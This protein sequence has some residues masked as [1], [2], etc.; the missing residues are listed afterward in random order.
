MIIVTCRDFSGWLE[1]SR[2]YLQFLT[3]L[4]CSQV[5]LVAQ[6]KSQQMRE[7]HLMMIKIRLHHLQWIHLLIMLLR[8]LVHPLRVVRACKRCVNVVASCM[9]NTLSKSSDEV[10]KSKTGEE[11]AV[12]VELQDTEDDEGELLYKYSH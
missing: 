11:A 7:Y 8:V 6:M 10:V 9:K 3:V 12:S 1:Q 4:R 2:S 5:T